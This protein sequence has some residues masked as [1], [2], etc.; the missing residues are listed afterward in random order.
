MPPLYVHKTLRCH[1]AGIQSGSDKCLIG[2]VS[3]GSIV[4][5]LCLMWLRQ[6]LPKLC[7]GSSVKV[8]CG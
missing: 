4:A 7:Y 6:N 2:S 3:A 5:S 1:E 8:Q